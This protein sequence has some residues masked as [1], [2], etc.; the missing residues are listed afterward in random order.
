MQVTEQLRRALYERLRDQLGEETATLVLEATVPANVELATRADIEVLRAEVI[1]RIVTAETALGARIDDLAARISAVDTSLGARISAVDTSLGARI[2][3]L[4]ARVDELAERMGALERSV[5][6][7]R[8]SLT[9][10]IM[11]RMLPALVATMGLFVAL[12]TWLAG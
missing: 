5:D 8:T 6:D 11:W 4:S 10:L 7:L 1:L 3:R 9:T 2:D 12:A